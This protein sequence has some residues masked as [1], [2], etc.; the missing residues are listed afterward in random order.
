MIMVSNLSI[1]QNNDC[2][3]FGIA[4]PTTIPQDFNPA[5]LDL[6]GSFKFNVEIKKCDEI[7]FTTIDSKENIYVSKKQNDK[8]SEPKIATFST[9]DYSDADPFLTKEGDRIYFIS[10]RP[11][12]PED[13][14]LDWNIWYADQ[15]KDAWT[16][17][18][19]LPEPI[20][21]AESNEYFFSISDKGNAFFS[22]NRAGGEGS[23]DIYTTKIL[24]NNQFSKPKN[25]GRPL[26]T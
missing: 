24:G 3:Y 12:S 18:M 10:K 15:E 8:W 21:S 2:N 23:F 4:K 9:P 26:S 11:T 13:K 22:S 17:P 6:N 19:P 25:V 5:I 20:N 16:S 7:Y 14:K 1:A